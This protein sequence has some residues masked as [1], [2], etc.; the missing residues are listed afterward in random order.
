[1]GFDKKC[2]TPAGHVGLQGIRRTPMWD[3]EGH[4]GLLNPGVREDTG[5]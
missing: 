1:M 2:G 5:T 4:V 3:P